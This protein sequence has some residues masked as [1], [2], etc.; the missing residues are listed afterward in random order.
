[1]ELKLAIVSHNENPSLPCNCA[2]QVT[3]QQ[4]PLKTFAVLKR[5]SLGQNKHNMLTKKKIY[6]FY[7]L[8]NTSLLHYKDATVSSSLSSDINSYQRL[9]E[10]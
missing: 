2:N 6:I 10:F 4:S 7:P 5:G 9:T 8:P 3:S 1:M